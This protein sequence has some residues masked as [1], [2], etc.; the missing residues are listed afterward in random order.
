L[1]RASLE[2]QLNDLDALK[3]QIRVVKRRLWEKRIAEWK[4]QDE[5]AAARGNNGML[6]KNGQ[7]QTSPAPV[8]PSS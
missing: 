6:M 3:S 2:R 4:R 5:E 1:E 8:K 7:W